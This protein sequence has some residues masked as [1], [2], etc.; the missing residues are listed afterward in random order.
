MYAYP[1]D[2]LGKKAPDQWFIGRVDYVLHEF[3]KSRNLP[4]M[5]DTTRFKVIAAICSA[6]INVNVTHSA[7]KQFFIDH[8]P[9]QIQ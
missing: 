2:N 1:L 7:V 8:P 4:N 9:A 5:T 3:I 6:A